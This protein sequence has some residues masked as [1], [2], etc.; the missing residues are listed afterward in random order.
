MIQKR[1]LIKDVIQSDSAMFEA[2]GDKVREIIKKH[3]GK[4]GD[5]ILDFTGIETVNTPFCNNAVGAL[6]SKYSVDVIS[7][8]KLENIDDTGIESFRIAIRNAMLQC[9]DVPNR[10]NR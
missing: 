1:I 2:Q 9:V 6:F 7:L 4:N 10:Q 8:I 5:I 3:I